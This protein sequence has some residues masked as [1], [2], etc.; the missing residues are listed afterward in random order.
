MSIYYVYAYLRAS[1]GTPY[2]IGKGKNG[3][4]FSPQHT[5]HKPTDPSRIVFVK[6]DLSEEMA[7]ELESSLIR[8]FKK[9]S[10][11]GILYNMTDGGGGISGYHHTIDAKKKIGNSHRNKFVSAE[12]REKISLMK[13]GKPAPNK[14]KPLSESQRSKLHD[15]LSEK[16]QCFH[17]DKIGNRRAMYRWHMNNCKSS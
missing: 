12:T 16:I 8:K 1:D 11:G 13:R 5:I 3:R 7:F 17:C 14:G 4:A 10:D 6:R 9:R 15:M 2:Y